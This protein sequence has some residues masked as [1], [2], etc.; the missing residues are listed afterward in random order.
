MRDDG[1]ELT[2]DR[3]VKCNRCGHSWCVR[4]A[5]AFMHVETTA[6]GAE[7]CPRCIAAIRKMSREWFRDSGSQKSLY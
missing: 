3:V 6:T 4:L 7:L 2:A 5:P 1:H